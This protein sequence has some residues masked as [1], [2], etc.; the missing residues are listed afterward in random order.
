MGYNSRRLKRGESM[1]FRKHATNCSV[2]TLALC[3]LGAQP[4]LLHGSTWQQLTP[5]V[6][7]S[8]RSYYSMAYDPV[9][10]KVVLFG[11]QGSSGNLNDTWTFDGTTWTQVTTAPAPPVRNG[12]A[13]GYDRPT[14]KL[15]LFG[16]FNGKQYLQDTWIWDGAASTWTQASMA[17]PPPSATGA[18]VFSDPVSGKATM[19]GG[20]NAT[21]IIP[22]SSFTWAWTGTAWNKL[23]PSTIPIPRGWGIAALDTLHH[24]VVLTGGTGDTIRTDNTWI[25][26]GT[27]WTSV[28]PA[29]QIEALIGAGYAFDPAEKAVVVFGGVAETWT[30]NGT[31]WT[32]LAPT[33]SPSARSGVSLAYD[34]VTRQTILFGGLLANGPL[35]NETWEFVGP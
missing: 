16:G 7:P 12:A 20:Y 29:T 9:S 2:F 17:S 13:M 21:K 23:S 27:N 34:P 35:T 5:A 26:D 22:V 28:L 14:K 31:T 1:G 33:I 25:W 15:I 24:N 4:V 10:K 8:A 19:Y 18:M 3:A 30:W 6:S 11:G 32:L